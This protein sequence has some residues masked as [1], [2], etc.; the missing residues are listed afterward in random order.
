M[1]HGARILLAGMA[2][3]AS[4]NSIGPVACRTDHATGSGS[5]KS[6]AHSDVLHAPG[7][8]VS[9]EERAH[10][11]QSDDLLPGP[12]ICYTIDS[13]AEIPDGERDTYQEAERIRS[14]QHGPR[15]HDTAIDPSAIRFKTGDR[16]DVSFSL[17]DR[18]Q[19]S[20]VKISARGVEL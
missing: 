1:R 14:A 18:G 4:L 13:F 12:H 20:I 9:V 17:G 10:D 2:C 11:E 15:C 3:A 7:T 19:I 5:A 8:I 16:V 6:P